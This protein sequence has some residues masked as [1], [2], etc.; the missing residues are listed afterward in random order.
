MKDI[1][2]PNG[3]E[4]ING[5]EHKRI[6][7]DWLK[8][9]LRSIK[10]RDFESMHVTVTDELFIKYAERAG[11]A[12]PILGRQEGL[13]VERAL[14]KIVNDIN[15]TLR[16]PVG[17]LLDKHGRLWALDT[18]LVTS[19]A[20]CYGKEAKLDWPD[21]FVVDLNKK[22]LI[23]YRNVLQGKGIEFI[24]KQVKECIKLHRLLK[25]GLRPVDMTYT[26]GDLMGRLT[27][28]DLRGIW[29]YSYYYSK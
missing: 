5:S 21:F 17:V 18:M 28:Y 22:Q 13:T 9:E 24:G 1:K 6:Q 7:E 15:S 19:Y 14:E 12:S 27:E 23:D 29:S 3:L 25:K 10:L 2:L 16:E 26:I 20:L 4:Y 11:Q 8:P